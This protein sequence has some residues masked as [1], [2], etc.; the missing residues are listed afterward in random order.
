MVIFRF[1]ATPDDTSKM[2]KEILAAIKKD[3]PY[4]GSEIESNVILSRKAV[5]VVKGLSLAIA[6]EMKLQVLI[7]CAIFQSIFTRQFQNQT[8]AKDL[9]LEMLR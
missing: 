3:N 2:I 1:V 8:Q 9:V 7:L 6:M 5:K 4:I